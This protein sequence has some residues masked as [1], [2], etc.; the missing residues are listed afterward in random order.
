MKIFLLFTIY[1]NLFAY[2]SLGLET[3]YQ[4]RL[5]RERIRHQEEDK[6]N[7]EQQQLQ[8]ENNRLKQNNESKNMSE[9]KDEVEEYITQF[10][11]SVSEISTIQDKQNKL[12]RYFV[13]LNGPDSIND[14]SI[15]VVD[16]NENYLKKVKLINKQYIFTIKE[17][18]KN[19]KLTFEYKNK[20]YSHLDFVAEPLI[21]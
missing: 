15:Q 20:K 12:K 2:G 7:K 16:N 4:S 1:L 18:I 19:F 13:I 8:E 10:N 6:K 9:L 17:N 21:N 5:V 14:F 3:D 11:V